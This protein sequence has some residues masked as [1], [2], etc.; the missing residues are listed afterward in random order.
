VLAGIYE[1]ECAHATLDA[2]PGILSE[3]NY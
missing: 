1:L 3:G 2:P